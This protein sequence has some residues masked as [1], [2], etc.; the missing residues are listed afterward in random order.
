MNFALGSTLLMHICLV[1]AFALQ[2]WCVALTFNNTS[3]KGSL[4]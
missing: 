4:R 3:Q 2:T 1:G